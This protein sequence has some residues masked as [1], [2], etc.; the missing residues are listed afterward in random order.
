MEHGML[1]KFIIHS[2]ISK[3]IFI[4][5]SILLV[6]ISL[7]WLINKYLVTP[8][9]QTQILTT[10]CLPRWLRSPAMA[11]RPNHGDHW[12]WVSHWVSG[13]GGGTVH[14]MKQ[15]VFEKKN[16][17]NCYINFSS[18]LYYYSSLLFNR[19]HKVDFF[20]IIRF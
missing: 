15:L 14:G 13:W 5:P 1:L 11:S 9:S 17:P 12:V 3:F 16:S 10:I 18:S 4:Y 6:I 8:R 20:W 19:I 2:F 7:S